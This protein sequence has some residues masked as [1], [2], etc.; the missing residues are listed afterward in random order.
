MAEEPGKPE[1]RPGEPGSPEAPAPTE[2]SDKPAPTEASG[3]PTRD[4]SAAAGRGRRRAVT[5]VAAVAAAAVL[6][7]GAWGASAWLGDGGTNSGGP[8]GQPL[9]LD[10]PAL[11]AGEPDA[12]EGAA[13]SPE[14]A[15]PGL[16]LAPEGDLP[17]APGPAEVYRFAAGPT[18]EEVAG[19]AAALGLDGTVQD[20]GAYWTVR[21]SDP[22]APLLTVQREAPGAWS[23]GVGPYAE[24]PERAE[25][26]AGPDETV[27]SAVDGDRDGPGEGA[28]AEPDHPADHTTDHT[29][30]GPG[31]GQAGAPGEA[32][33]RAA[34]SGV[35]RELGLAEEQSAR[36][37]AS[38]VT[39]TERLV[40]ATPLLA[41]LPVLGFE[42]E[43]S[44]AADG[45]LTSAW[46][47]LAEPAAAEE[48]ETVG[49]GE[50]LAAFNER[51]GPAT[52]EDLSCPLIEPGPAEPGEQP[53][54]AAVPDADCLPAGEPAPA[55]AEFGLAFASSAGEPLLVPSWLFHVRLPDGDSRTVWEPAVDHE[56]AAAR[57]PGHAEGEN[58]AP[59]GQDADG[60]EPG[61]G[62]EPGAVGS[63]EPAEPAEGAQPAGAA[64]SVEPY[65][66][67]DR[68]LTVHFW[69]GVCSDHRAT[70]EETGDRIE[71]RIEQVGQE[72]AETCILLAEEETAEVTLN[73]PVGGRT[74]TDE[75]GQELPVR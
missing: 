38:E 50:A 47:M 15:A 7:G 51:G 44:V 39:G 74:V 45:Q 64:M 35:L 21:G 41:G 75:R 33:A 46:G 52:A 18:E 59:G 4:G 48:R 37:D 49:A 58:P 42:T 16:R 28:A 56:Y 36:V 62:E 70:A 22:Q 34:V 25:R 72:R 57:E 5:V 71:V 55:T 20:G 3:E 2:A 67:G 31:P 1:D 12:S 14:P 24:P 66:A 10:S 19:L 73:E 54:I 68:T 63:A 30:D 9:L 11:H 23:Y 40:R 32:E 61:A 43:F 8:G 17:A 29:S 69:G 53:E 27:S 60:G 13:E 6:A 65:E 26:T